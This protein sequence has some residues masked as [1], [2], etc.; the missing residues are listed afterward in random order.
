MKKISKRRRLTENLMRLRYNTKFHLQ[1]WAILSQLNEH[2]AALEDA[3]NASEFCQE[4][5]KVSYDLWLEIMKD[6]QNGSRYERKNQKMG[7]RKVSKSENR[8]SNTSDSPY[9]SKLKNTMNRVF[10]NLDRKRTNRQDNFIDRSSRR[11]HIKIF[12]NSSSFSSTKNKA[13]LNESRGAKSENNRSRHSSI[14]SSTSLVIRESIDNEI[15]E[16]VHTFNLKRGSTYSQGD[17]SGDSSMNWSNRRN[18][19]TS[20]Q[21]A[22]YVSE[23]VKI[24]DSEMERTIHVL[25]E[26]LR[27]VDEFNK[28]RGMKTDKRV[29]YLQQRLGEKKR[30]KISFTDKEEI[31]RMKVDNQYKLNVRSALGIKNP[32]DW[33]FNLN[34]G[35]VMHMSPIGFDDLHSWLSLDSI[36]KRCV[37]ELSKDSLLE[38]IVLLT[39]GYFCVGTE[40]RFLMASGKNKSVQK[41]SE[42]WHAKA[43]HTS[44]TF[45]PGDC[46]LVSHVTSSYI[47]HHLTQKMEDRSYNKDSVISIS[48]SVPSKATNAKT[49]ISQNARDEEVDVPDEGK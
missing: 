1:L 32:D 29:D 34:I 33:I 43:L 35:N 22:F 48:T 7:G 37:Y 11:N 42:M 8:Q 24:Q 46:P 20:M 5:L 14:S 41:D 40:L 13:E 10:K 6:K 28:I 2:E 49:S 38:K 21:R 36:E 17:L 30:L 4:S 16:Q 45:L 47:K 25:G 15:L 9:N 26:I 12:K 19:T 18:S 44:S 31:E 3:K 39:V 23:L 27:Q